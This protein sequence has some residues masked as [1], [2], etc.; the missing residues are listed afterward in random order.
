MGITASLSVPRL[1][2]PKFIKRRNR[3]LN[4]T[5]FS[6]NFDILNR[7]HYFKMAQFNLSFSYD[8]QSSRYSSH[9]LTPFKITYTNLLK[10]TH[11]FD[12]I[13]GANPAI[14]LSSE[15]NTSHS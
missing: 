12:S 11:A 7:P 2:A 3:N 14:A 8:W 5:R 9:T 4:W 1:L 10:T 6:L 13:T 15:A